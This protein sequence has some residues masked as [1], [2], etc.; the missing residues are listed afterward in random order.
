MREAGYD[1]VVHPA[2]LDEEAYGA[3]LMPAELARR[4][5]IVKAEA[6]AGL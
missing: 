4:L 5:A 6:V 1:F 2:N 3:G